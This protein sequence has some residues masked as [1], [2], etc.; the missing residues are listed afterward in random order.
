[1][2]EAKMPHAGHEKHL[3]YLHNLGYLKSNLGDYKA[4]VKNP[5]FVCKACGRTA[6]KEENLC[7]AEAL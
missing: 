5:K 4:L 2:A 7:A 6:A 3:C 1:M